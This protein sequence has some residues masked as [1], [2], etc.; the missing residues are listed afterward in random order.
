MAARTPH[1]ILTARHGASPRG[2]TKQGGPPAPPRTASEQ[3]TA[4]GQRPR[5]WQRGRVTRARPTGPDAH[6]SGR[7]D[8][9]DPTDEAN[10]A[11]YR[12]HTNERQFTKVAD[13][14]TCAPDRPPPT[15]PDAGRPRETTRARHRPPTADKGQMCHDVR[16]RARERPTACADGTLARGKGCFNLGGRCG[17]RLARA[18]NFSPSIRGGVFGVVALG[19][20]FRYAGRF[21]RDGGAPWEVCR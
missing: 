8:T 6:R 13:R 17:P 14:E 5:R 10:H 20:R 21:D 2:P 4:R 9:P 12:P 18:Y 1:P 3:A 7:G 15:G 16:Y 11:A 19:W